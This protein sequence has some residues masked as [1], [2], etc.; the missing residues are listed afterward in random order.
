VLIFNKALWFGTDL[1]FSLINPNQCHSFGIDLCDDPFDPNC[2]FGFTNHITGILI[3]FEMHGSIAG[4]TSHLPT[5][6]EIETCRHNPTECV[7]SEF[8]HK[9]KHCAMTL[10]VPRRLWDYGMIWKAEVLP[11]TAH[12]DQK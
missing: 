4:F 2:Q 5:K 8:K 6:H 9:W 7:I 10:N 11:R 1:P 12:S 3:P